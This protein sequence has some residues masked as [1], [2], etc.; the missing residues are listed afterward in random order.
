ME[1]ERFYLGP[2]TTTGLWADWD[3]AF[4]VAL[5]PDWMGHDVKNMLYT[6]AVENSPTCRLW[7]KASGKT[8]G[9]L[10]GFWST[11]TWMVANAIWGLQN[12]WQC[13]NN[14]IWAAELWKDIASQ[15]ENLA[16]KVCHVDAH[17]PRSLQTKHSPS[18]ALATWW[19]IGNLHLLAMVLQRSFI[20][21]YSILQ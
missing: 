9:D 21:A 4:V 18:G 14:P 1:E 8:Q 13:R 20:T 16:I 10:L 11:D 12:N 3:I 6:T 19:R 5:G 7:W 2:W 15:E 17:I